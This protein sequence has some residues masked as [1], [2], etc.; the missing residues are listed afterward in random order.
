MSENIK[1]IGTPKK[2]ISRKLYRDGEILTV[3]FKTGKNLQLSLPSGLTK[4]LKLN[5]KSKLFC[6]IVGNTVQLC[7]NQPLTTIPVAT[8]DVEVYESHS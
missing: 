1:S 6:A 2:P 8:N 7:G 3:P 4:F 5:K